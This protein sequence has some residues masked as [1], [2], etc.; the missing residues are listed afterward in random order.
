MP[1]LL[2]VVL[3]LCVAFVSLPARADTVLLACSDECSPALFEALELELRGHGGVL[4]ARP[5]P[6]GFTP[7]ARG[8]DALRL[9][10]LLG[11]GA[12]L[13]IE[14]ESPLRVRAY[15]AKSGQIHEAPLNAEV[16]ALEPKLFA[17]V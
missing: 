15:S 8:A 13:W 16:N 6:A 7:S 9:S 11:A 12:T 14:H 10:Q 4:V 5:A 3:A 1:R 17:A 2:L